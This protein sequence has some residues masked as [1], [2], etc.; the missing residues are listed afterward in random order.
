ML[1]SSRATRLSGRTWGRMTSSPVIFRTLG[2][3][4][5]RNRFVYY[6]CDCMLRAGSGRQA[7]RD[8]SFDRTASERHVRRPRLQDHV[9]RSSAKYLSGS[10]CNHHACRAPH[11]QHARRGC[12]RQK[13]PE[14]QAAHARNHARNDRRGE[15]V[16]GAQA[17]PTEQYLLDIIMGT[18]THAHPRLRL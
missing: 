6:G 5:L 14:S 4:E 10:A 13:R 3:P 11:A 8:S 9:K 15:R 18:G 12:V 17:H 16:Y 7:A 1:S 2:R